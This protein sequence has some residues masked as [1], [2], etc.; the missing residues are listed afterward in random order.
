MSNH[1]FDQTSK[2]IS[3]ILRH[4]PETIGITLDEHG[5]A[6]V[7]ELIAGISKTHPIDMAI[8]EQIV[9]E[10]EKQRYS[11]N[12]DK[13]LIRA[14]QGHSIP[15]DVELEAKQP[16][17]ILYHGT[18][19]KY[20][21]SINEQGLIPKSRLYVHLSGDEET[22]HKVGQRHGKPV[23]YQVKSGDMYR[24]GHKFFYSVNGVWLT[25]S[26]PVKY[27]SLKNM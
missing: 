26:V 24:D 6:N 18:G 8:L 12:E 9:A 10:D 16:P 2:Y 27:L 20:V 23:I 11:F 3:L 5:W 25:K 13:T 19:E 7:D 15:V 4:K 22:A 21:S 14:N 17:E 1:K